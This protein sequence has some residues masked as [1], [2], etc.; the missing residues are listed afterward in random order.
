MKD[1]AEY[2]RQHGQG[3]DTVLAH[4]NPQEAR[5][6]AREEGFDMN[7]DTGLPQFGLKKKLKKAKKKLG[8]IAKK[9]APFASV[10]PGIGPV[11]SAALG[12]GGALLSGGGLK[13]ALSSGL[14]GGLGSLALG[15]GG[16][17]GILGKLPGIGGALGQFGGAVGSPF[18][19][20]EGALA[21]F[22]GS[23]PTLSKVLGGAANQVAGGGGAPG[24]STWD[25]IQNALGIGGTGGQVLGAG[26]GGL[27]GYLS[28]DDPIKTSTKTSLPSWQEEQI[29]NGMAQ[30]RSLYDSG[31]FG[32]VAELSD[33]T[34][35]GIAGLTGPGAT[36]PYKQMQSYLQGTLGQD[37]APE[38]SGYFKDVIGGKYLSGNPHLDAVIGRAQDD[39]KSRFESQYA[40]GG[41]RRSGAAARGLATGLGDLSNQMR[42]TDYNNERGRMGEAGNSLA[43]IGST[44]RGYDLNAVQGMGSAQDAYLNA[45][46][47]GTAAGGILDANAQAQ[48]D[49]PGKALAQYQAGNQGS[50]GGTVDQT[51]DQNAFL[52][53]LAGA[54]L[55]A[56]VLGPQTP[57][58][59]YPLPQPQQQ[60]SG[61]D[62]DAL[63]QGGFGS[64]T[65]QSGVNFGTSGSTSIF[66]NMMQ[67]PNYSSLFGGQ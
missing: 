2:L 22:F 43:T 36:D 15:A 20:A 19:G 32:R 4:I 14:Q 63:M 56:S 60:S 40:S 61:I 1:V 17:S 65:P 58:Y 35:R 50:Y 51:Q 7:P 13:G 59:Q 62:W 29:K 8:K 26:L 23:N 46:K 67:Q 18:A 39:V 27:A 10:I 55:G 24:G 38:A 34:K 42:Y 9:V 53:T 33:E 11:A 49:A 3:G 54:G 21:S 37:T 16:M 66:G 30:N 52:N 57:A 28:S 6:L 12:A 48:L 45:L 64:T 41:R 5:M 44:N 25:S 31:Q 47:A